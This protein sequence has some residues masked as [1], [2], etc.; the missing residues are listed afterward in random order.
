MTTL[1][2]SG[3]SLP[4][5]L[6]PRIGALA[7]AH[8]RRDPHTCSHQQRTAA[9]A[10]AIGAILDLSSGRLDTLR[11]AA[12]MHD[13]GKLGLP[14][15]LIGKPGTL[16]QSEYALLQKHC[17]I[18]HD[19]LQQ[20]RAPF[21]VAEIV[22]QHHERLDGSGYPRGLKGSAILEE[23][24]ILAVADTVDAMLSER[25]YRTPSTEDFVLGELQ[26]VAGRTLDRD[27][28]DA[29][30]RYVRSGRTLAAVGSSRTATDARQQ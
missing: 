16:S 19:V 30:T 20:L 2:R 27:A 11:I 28:V 26:K 12:T 10:V 29:C 21:P 6:P 22:F 15:E 1:D 9:L 24:R 8:R 3:A 7:R 5:P 17:A 23:A 14:G 4:H 25:P 13:I 18:G